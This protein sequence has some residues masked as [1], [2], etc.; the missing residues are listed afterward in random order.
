MSTMRR[1]VA[2]S[3]LLSAALIGSACASPGRALFGTGGAAV[4]EAVQVTA[5]NQNYSD[6]TV[7]ALWDLGPRR[8]LGMVT[9]LTSETFDLSVHGTALRFQIDFIGGSEFTTDEI[10]VSAGDDLLVR[11]PPR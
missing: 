10:V 1:H 2:A 8:R 6:A 5:D 3:T 11:I 7:Y 9:G 4:E